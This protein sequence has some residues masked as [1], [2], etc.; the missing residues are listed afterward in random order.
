MIALELRVVPREITAVPAAARLCLG[1]SC[2]VWLDVMNG[3]WPV[4]RLTLFTPPLTSS[5][6]HPVT[7]ALGSGDFTLVF[8]I[9]ISILSS[10]NSF[11]AS[12]ISVRVFFQD[13]RN[14]PLLSTSSWKRNFS[15]FKWYLTL[16][17]E[18]ACNSLALSPIW[19]DAW[20]NL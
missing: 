15:S 10:I 5:S 14:S 4:P 8:Y 20:R 12:S 13:L 3:T 16:I 2:A 1:R 17:L 19:G 11:A 7:C 18:A 9:V 6:S